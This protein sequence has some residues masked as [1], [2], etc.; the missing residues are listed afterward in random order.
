M[1][2]E[3]SSS[4]QG[5]VGDDMNNFLP[6]AGAFIQALL[7]GYAGLRLLES[8]GARGGRDDGEAGA[9]LRLMPRCPP[10]VRGVRLRRVA[11]LGSQLALNYTTA[12]MTVSLD[13]SPP[14]GHQLV[15]VLPND[16]KDGGSARRVQLVVGSA[17]T[18]PVQEAFIVDI[19]K[20]QDGVAVTVGTESPSVGV[21]GAAITAA[22]SGKDRTY[23]C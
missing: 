4:E 15:L 8:S 13:R 12:T 7:H 1:W 10:G 5:G 23:V 19:L 20:E 6:A 9:R 11:L 2:T 22:G 14:S 18:V 16:T 17:V 3:R 21:V